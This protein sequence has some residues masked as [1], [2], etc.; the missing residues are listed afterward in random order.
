MKNEEFA[1]KQKIPTFVAV[2][3]I[4]I[5]MTFKR[6]VNQNLRHYTRYYILIA[7]AVALANTIITGSLFVGDSVRQTLISRVDERLGNTLALITSGNTFMDEA[8][9]RAPALEGAAATVFFTNG[10][11]PDGLA[12]QPVSVWGVDSS[13][14]AVA[15]PGF[16]FPRSGEVV[17]N[18]KMANELS[19]KEDDFIVVRLPNTSMIPSGSLFVRDNYTESLRLRVKA[20]IDSRQ[21]GNMSLRNEQ[22]IPFNLFVNRQQLTYRMEMEGKCNIIMLNRKISED[23]LI[24][25]WAPHFSGI[26]VENKDGYQEI[27]SEAIFLDQNLV[28]QLNGRFPQ[29]NHLFSY[30]VNDIATV[31]TASVASASVPY[32]FVTAIDR[33]AG[34]ELTGDDMILTDYAATRLNAKI[35]D[36]ITL[37]FFV[38][39]ELKALTEESHRFIVREIMPLQAFL[40]DGRLSAEYPGLYDVDSCNDWDSDLPIDMERIEKEDEDYWDLY[41]TTPKALIAYSKAASLW[42]N[43]YGVATA[44]R[45]AGE[46]KIALD[47]IIS[48]ADAG[49]A[50]VSPRDAG[51]TAAMEGIDFTT[52]FLSLAFFVIAAALL[53]AIIPLGGMLHDRG[54]E[55]KLLQ[56]LGYNEKRINKILISEIALM[57]VIATLTGMFTAVMYN[58]LVLFALENIWKGAVH[59]ENIMASIKALS[60]ILGAFSS[61]VVCFATVWLALRRILN[62]NQKSKIENQKSKFK[63]QKSNI[64]FLVCTLVVFPL[65]LAIVQ[66]PSLYIVT[67][68][69]ALLA[70]ITGY[71]DIIRR[72]ASRTLSV[73]SLVYKNLYYRRRAGII[74][75]SALSCGVFVVFSVGLNRADFSNVVSGTG[76]F[77]LWGE[78]SVP[79]YHTLSTADGRARYGLTSMPAEVEILQFYRRGGD[80][81]SCLNINKAP[82]PT[83]LGVD[84]ERLSQ[85]SFTFANAT[86]LSNP[87][88]EEVWALLSQKRGDF[89]P[90][91]ADQTVLQWGLMKTVGDTIM[92]LN[93]RGEPVVLQFVAGLNNSIFQGNLLIDKSFFAEIWGEDGSEVML[94]QT[95]DSLRYEVR[96]LLSHAL[97]NYGLQLSFSNERLREFN[98]VADSYLTIFLMLGGLGLLIGMFG[99]LLVIKR[100]I[101]DRAGELSVLLAIGFDEAKIRKQLFRESMTAPVYAIVAGT[102]AAFMAVASA[103]TAV[104]IFTWAIMLAIVVMLIVIAWIYAKRVFSVLNQGIIP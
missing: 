44:M 16:V 96:Q 47:E 93:R 103:L 1:V 12:L 75:V 95:A 7:L 92:Y 89:Y 64:F 65:N 73:G 22:S 80:D 18:R 56:A 30:L 84:A 49:I 24:N 94:V 66:S 55:M 36:S 68:L 43:N 15:A 59:T 5:N 23:E 98:S 41:R 10:F 72:G 6:L 4:K 45:I 83:V 42:A 37:A 61:L 20:V 25:S 78:N 91:I 67:G 97:A 82:Q 31:A 2:K 8:F 74:S 76:G 60:L 57:T 19:L 21:S 79:L 88:S 34:I 40:D 104:S 35:G 62:E 52:L 39:A 100:G 81:A 85:A 101:L 87:T 102:V 13:L 50:V 38:S 48:P 86:D 54:T 33:F 58:R 77:A 46:D 51:L 11:V 32:S 99:M 17:I 53:L 28:S 29:T 63:I 27:I 90:V 69:T 14:T 26:T 70:F 3:N 71:P 9:A